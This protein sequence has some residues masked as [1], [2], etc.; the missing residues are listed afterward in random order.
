MDLHSRRLGIPSFLP[1]SKTMGEGHTH[2]P[3]PVAR[4]HRMG[5]AAVS[6][7]PEA[8]QALWVHP[9][10]DL[11]LRTLG[12]A[13]TKVSFPKLTSPFLGWVAS[14]FMASIITLDVGSLWIPRIGVSLARG[15]KPYNPKE[16]TD[17]HHRPL[18][19][20]V[21]L[22]KWRELKAL[23]WPNFSEESQREFATGPGVLFVPTASYFLLRKR[24]PAGDATFLPYETLKGYK[25]SFHHFL[26]QRAE[27]PW[28]KV[29]ASLT[30]RI[31]S[32][33]EDLQAFLQQHLHSP[34]HHA[35]LTHP[36]EVPAFSKTP[37]STRTL[38]HAWQNTLV[39]LHEGLLSHQLK[40][41]INLG[42]HP[43]FKHWLQAKEH[44]L[45][46]LAG[47]ITEA[48][49][50]ANEAIRP[51]TH[52]WQKELL[53]TAWHSHPLPSIRELPIGNALKELK[54]FP[55]YVQRVFL[56]TV[57]KTSM[58]PTTL[59]TFSKPLE[60]VSNANVIQTSEQLY[61]KMLGHKLGF[62]LANTALGVGW[63]FWLASWVLKTSHVYPAN[64]LMRIDHLKA[65]MEGTGS[66][67][68]ALP[69]L[70][71]SS[72]K[73][74]RVPSR[75]GVKVLPTQE[76]TQPP[77]MKHSQASAPAIPPQEA[78][79]AYFM[80]NIETATLYSHLPMPPKEVSV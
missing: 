33:R 26:S 76:T 55:S 71:E 24:L 9:K 10:T 18:T 80:P 50:L 51:E 70:E 54:L 61:Q 4:K 36:V 32:S 29:G 47:H 22:S 27:A 14:S 20:R 67:S 31:Q 30:Q 65:G 8:T 17:L 68:E 2:S 75:S 12:D 45:D 3:S 37:T 40:Q 63:L 49:K 25:D 43:N 16:D 35:L 44:H 39:D 79:K 57:A 23:N 38:L 72:S 69:N 28:Q 73:T 60:Q 13:I 58:T 15:A 78:P 48:V 41:P 42:E 11:L 77:S 74:G 6:A 19:Q 1:P 46:T 7:V 21:L 52:L 5:S 66:I 56:D 34:D 64:R 53:P 59:Q 62:S